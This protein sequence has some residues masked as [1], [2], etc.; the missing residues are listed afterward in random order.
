MD[1]WTLS[2]KG[3]SCDAA[4][5]EAGERRGGECACC[6]PRVACPCGDINPHRCAQCGLHH[7]CNNS[8]LIIYYRR[9]CDEGLGLY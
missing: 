2:G 8:K 4:E 9:V 6:V 1:L 3:C 7:H 5:G